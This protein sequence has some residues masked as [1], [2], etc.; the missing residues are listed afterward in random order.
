MSCLRGDS[1]RNAGPRSKRTSAAPTACLPYGVFRAPANIA[2]V[3]A[4]VE[5]LVASQPE[6]APRLAAYHAWALHDTMDDTIGPLMTTNNQAAFALG[7][8]FGLMLTGGGR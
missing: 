4:A 2:A 5:R 8:A 7:L 6:A 3:D 1:L